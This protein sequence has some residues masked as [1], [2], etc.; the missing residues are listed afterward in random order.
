MV[1]CHLVVDPRTKESRGFG[2]VTMESLE[3]ADRCIKHLNK[4]IL[5]GRVITVE[6]VSW[7][8][9][10]FH[11]ILLFVFVSCGITSLDILTKRH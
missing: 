9:E 7:F 1:E 4:S 6:K 10:P 2:F 8:Y 5:E 11:L 3:G